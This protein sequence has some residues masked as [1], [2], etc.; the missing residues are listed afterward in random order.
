M[1][2]FTGS[3]VD[4]VRVGC[5]PWSASDRR[6]DCGGGPKFVW[7]ADFG[8]V[9]APGAFTSYNEL[10]DC[11]SAKVGKALRGRYGWYIDS[12]QFVCDD[13]NK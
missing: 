4:Q 2:S 11:P 9:G 10:V 13:Y 6:P 12:L 5:C 3:F 8:T 1:S 7:L